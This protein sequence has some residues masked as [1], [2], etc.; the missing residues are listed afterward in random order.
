MPDAHQ[1]DR[2]GV[3]GS[4][5]AAGQAERAG[6]KSSALDSEVSCSKATLA[7]G[8]PDCF[9]SAAYL[10]RKARGEPLKGA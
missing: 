8:A 7:K 10:S 9:K 2:L 4:S 3:R 1:A 6:S 5:G